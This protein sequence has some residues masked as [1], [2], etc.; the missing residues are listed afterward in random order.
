[1]SFEPV[2]RAVMVL[3]L[4]VELK[5]AP[6]PSFQMGWPKRRL[7]YNVGGVE[8]VLRNRPREL[9]TYSGLFM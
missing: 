5:K 9:V 1:M 3:P 7:D 2:M 8:L 6:R 4:R